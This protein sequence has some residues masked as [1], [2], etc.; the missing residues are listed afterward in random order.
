MSKKITPVPNPASASAIKQA[1]KRKTL[2][3][4]NNKFA[5]QQGSDLCWAACMANIARQLTPANTVQ[6][7]AE[8][9]FFRDYGSVPGRGSN[10]PLRKSYFLE[11]ARNIFGS[12]TEL[13]C[14]KAVQDNLNKGIYTIFYFSFSGSGRG[15]YV[16]IYGY[17]QNTSDTYYFVHDPK[18][19]RVGM[20][21]IITET[22]L[23]NCFQSNTGSFTI[24]E[25]FGLFALAIHANGAILKG[26]EEK[27]S[28]T[29]L[30]LLVDEIE[31]TG[32]FHDI[33]RFVLSS[34]PYLKENVNLRGVRKGT[35]YISDANPS[36]ERL[37]GKSQGVMNVHTAEFGTSIVVPAIKK[38]D[39]NNRL[40]FLTGFHYNTNSKTFDRAEDISFI[41]TNVWLYT[42]IM[43]FYER[44]FAIN[45]YNDPNG[46]MNFI[47]RFFNGKEVGKEEVF[48]L[49]PGQLFD[50]PGGTGSPVST[51]KIGEFTIRTPGVSGLPKDI[52]REKIKTILDPKGISKFKK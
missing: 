37:D 33:K 38:S 29:S 20:K 2:V 8:E 44:G 30:S 1:F 14:F 49:S 7:Y 36:A 28:A 13:N 4:E 3:L 34:S 22:Y 40:E 45:A 50:K 31:S 23:K 15:H 27:K 39:K 19:D 25:N 17:E 5:G 9:N 32:D 24:G 11:T 46:D 35:V 10:R 43:E 16:I 12:F 52:Y 51:Q 18:P 21:Y 48:K 6:P 42:K 47:F 41:N 26:R